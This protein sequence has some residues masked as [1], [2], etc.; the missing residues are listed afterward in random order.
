MLQKFQF[1]VIVKK[2][3]AS[4]IANE[5]GLESFGADIHLNGV[6]LANRT[7]Q[8]ENVL[9][10]CVDESFLKIALSNPGV[11]AIVIPKEL[12]AACQSIKNKGFIVSKTPEWTFYCIYEYLVKKGFFDTPT[13][14][15]V[16]NNASIGRGV[17]IEDNV[18]LGHNVV[19]GHN[20]VIKKNT[21][22]GDNTVIGNACVIGEDGFQIIYD[23]DGHPHTITHVGRVLI[24]N[25]V[26][27]ADC[28]TINRSLFEGETHIADYV[29]IDSHSQ[30]SHNVSVGKNSVL[31]S[32]VNMLGSSSVGENV[33]VA[34]NT[35]VMN[36]VHIG[37]KAFIGADSLVLKNIAPG[38]KAFGHP[39]EE[40]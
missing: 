6:N 9:S 35:V 17:V 1:E 7:F 40:R 36:K 20:S 21:V 16:I 19:I 28:V 5:F 31:A 33:W 4:S 11:G 10:Y 18:V 22:I 2:Y 29:K 24:G 14:P 3:S 23:P 25:N 34:P 30:L 12:V 15:S 13:M 32:C 39:A 27:I 8:H 37:D 38:V 26:S